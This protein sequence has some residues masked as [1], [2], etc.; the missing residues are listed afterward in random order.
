MLSAWDH[1][2]TISASDAWTL[3]DRLPFATRT[4]SSVVD[5]VLAQLLVNDSPP[6]IVTFVNAVALG[7]VILLT[8]AT[9]SGL[10]LVV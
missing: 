10:V 2:S 8:A 5:P 4:D 6:A 7:A 1:K 3:T 9:L